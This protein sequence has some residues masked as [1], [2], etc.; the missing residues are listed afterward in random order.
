[1][2]TQLNFQKTKTRSPKRLFNFRFAVVLASVCLGIGLL[3]P[4]IKSRTA[5]HHPLPRGEF[6][7]DART[8]VAAMRYLLDPEPDIKKN[9]A[10]FAGSPVTFTQRPPGRT[11]EM[12][13]SSC[14]STATP[15]VS[16]TNLPAQT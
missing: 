9:P 1:M 2:N 3:L 10:P 4:V 11:L 12:S 6:L 15:A 7:A 14:N 5:K 16:S 8:M 13:D